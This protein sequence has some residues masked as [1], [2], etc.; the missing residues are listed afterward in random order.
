MGETGALSGV[1]VADFGR[2]LA[3]PY[4]TMLLADLGAEVVKVERRGSGDET[5]AWGP[6]FAGDETTYFLGVNRNKRSI[7]LDLRDPDDL[8][9]ARALAARADVLVEN[10]RPGTM[11][12]LGLGYADLVK[13]NPRLIYCSITGFG[14]AGGAA[15]P[16]YDLLVQAVGGLM[17]VTGEPGGEPIKTG[18]AVVDVL[19]GLHACVGIL[20]ALRHRDRTGEGQRV[21]V[22]L[23]SSLLSALVNQSSAYVAAGVVPTAMGNR[24][25]SIAPYEVYATADRPMVLAVGNDKQFRA[26]CSVI[27]VPELSS[28]ERFATNTKRVANREALNERLSARLSTRTADAWFAALTEAGVPCG[29]INDLAAA[30]EFATRLGLDPVVEIDDPHRDKPVRQVANPITL[31]CTPP[32]YHKAPPRLG[33]DEAEVLQMLGIRR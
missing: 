33:E 27:G 22:S 1:L 31:S 23:L 26:L 9:V 8:E 19:T 7:A 5:R 6:P 28:D 32:K 20:A 16:G 21:E 11:D 30:F 4:A 25:P 12:R 29:P 3:A 15:L 10:F 13:V 2:V 18:V 24:H 14:S 17:S